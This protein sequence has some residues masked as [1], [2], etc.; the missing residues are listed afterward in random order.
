MLEGHMR[1]PIIVLIIIPFFD[2]KNWI[3]NI[4]LATNDPPVGFGKPHSLRLTFLAF[5]DLAN[6]SCL[7]AM[8]SAFR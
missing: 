5:A 7:G 4:I 1:P 2:S 6:L 3:C 8:I